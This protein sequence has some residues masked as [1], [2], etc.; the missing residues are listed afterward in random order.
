MSGSAS[1]YLENKLIDHALGTTTFTK[2]TTVYVGLYTVPPSDSSTG[3]T[4]G[5]EVTGGSY[6]R[7][8]ATFT[9]ASGGSA[10]NNANIDFTGM[11]ACTVSAV[12]IFDDPDGGNLLFWST[13]ATS[14]TLTAGDA[15]RISTG[16]LVVT[17]N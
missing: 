12:G 16:A 7:Q 17:L 10:A 5:T 3:T 2:P 4:G 11:P 14:R 8:T 1:D 9:A 15:V 13:L 6:D